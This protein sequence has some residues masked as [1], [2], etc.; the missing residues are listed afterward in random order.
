MTT[1]NKTGQLRELIC[2]S[3][4]STALAINRLYK[5]LLDPLGL[6]Y[7]QFLVPWALWEEDGL[8]IGAI[9][10]RLALE[11]STI[12]P[13]VKR[14]EQ[15]GFVSRNRCP[16]DERQVHVRLTQKGREVHDKTGCLRDAML[17]KTGMSG[18]D[19]SR[20]N[21]DVLHLLDRLV[22]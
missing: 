11:P 14:L 18:E 8:G 13:L 3:V 1:D 4:Y 12:T 9:A 16:V 21:K 10:E 20:L 6:T 15:A 2:F 5:P 17:E 7:P 19:L 22:A